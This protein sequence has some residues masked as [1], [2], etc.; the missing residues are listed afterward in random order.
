M[1]RLQDFHHTPDEVFNIILLWVIG[2]LVRTNIP[3]IT[4][5]LDKPPH[6]QLNDLLLPQSIVEFRNRW[7]LLAQNDFV[8]LGH[9]P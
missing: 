1:N 2:L 4:E 8:S 3:D 5:M 6:G 9:V 7:F